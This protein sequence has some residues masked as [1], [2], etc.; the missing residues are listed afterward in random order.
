M[1]QKGLSA[2]E[3]DNIIG[4]GST[5]EGGNEYHYEEAINLSDKGFGSFDRCLRILTICQGSTK[6]AEKFLSKLMLKETKQQMEN[7]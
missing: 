4:V 1:N 2:K 7:E 5:S 6:E 3:I